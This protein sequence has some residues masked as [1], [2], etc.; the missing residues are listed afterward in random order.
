MSINL[1]QL[2]TANKA[3]VE[4]LQAVA[5]VALASA[6]RIATLNLS[7][8]R[9]AIEDSASGAKA[10]LAA[11]NAKEA[12]DIQSS[13][14][15][16]ALEKAVGYSR[17][18]YEIATQGQGELTKLMEAQ[19]AGFQKSLAEAVQQSARSLPQGTVGGFGGI[20]S[21]VDNMNS[22]FSRMN[23]MSRQFAELAQ[24]NF[25]AV[26]QAAEAMTKGVRK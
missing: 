17:S 6:E 24:A 20:Q 11:K 18:I 1:E 16:P 9:A 25:S 22:S 2:A 12:V 19:F 10:V 26:T 13:L 23:E 3:A 21:A 7:T 14:A 8:A 15:Q 4:S 5:N